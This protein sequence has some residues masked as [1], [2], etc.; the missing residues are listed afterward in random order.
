MFKRNMYW[1]QNFKG[2]Q[3][4]KI[5]EYVSGTKAIEQKGFG[6]S[7]SKYCKKIVIFV[8]T[9]IKFEALSWKCDIFC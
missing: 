1:L 5:L 6:L 4:A 2:F 9:N 8:S 3:M 7:L